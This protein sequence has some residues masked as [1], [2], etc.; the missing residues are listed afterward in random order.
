MSLTDEIS[1][2]Q[3]HLQT[4]EQIKLTVIFINSSNKNKRTLNYQQKKF[5]IRKVNGAKDPAKIF[6]SVSLSKQAYLPEILDSTSTIMEP[7]IIFSRNLPFSSL[8]L[9]FVSF[10][11]IFVLCSAFRAVLISLQV[12]KEQQFSSHFLS[13]THTKTCG[14]FTKTKS[15]L[16]DLSLLV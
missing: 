7:I 14:Q 16:I 8:P 12:T 13:F 3:I 15:F 10:G 1:K 2:N 6:T 5:R 4:D 9:F 11:P